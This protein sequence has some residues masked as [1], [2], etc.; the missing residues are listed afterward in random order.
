MKYKSKSIPICINNNAFYLN[1]HCQDKLISL[2]SID[3][4]YCD[5]DCSNDDFPYY[6]LYVTDFCNKN[7]KFC[8]NSIDNKNKLKHENITYD[9]DSLINFI[10]K[11]SSEFSLRFF[12]GEPT[13][14]FN[15][16]KEI[17]GKIE[18]EDIIGHFN[19]FTNGILLTNENLRYM[20]DKNI[21]LFLSIPNNLKELNSIQ[22]KNIF[23][24]IREE[25]M[26]DNVTARI[27]WNP[28]IESDLKTMVKTIIDSEI[29]LVSFTL[30]WG[31]II[32]LKEKK[33]I[34]TGLID[35]AD[36][37]IRE[38]KEYNFKYIGVHPIN[39]YIFK[40]V[41]GEYSDNICGAGKNLVSISTDGDLHPCHC[42]NYNND[43]KCGNIVDGNWTRAFDKQN[44]L[45]ISSCVN[46]EYNLFCKAKCFADSYFVNKDILAINKSKCE[47]EKI[48]IEISSY[49]LSELLKNP[50]QFKIYKRLLERG[51]KNYGNNI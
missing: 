34:K 28:K 44:T 1:P 13:L 39:S 29:K 5:V 18:K 4:G 20:K 30:E 46:C 12:G 41:K 49:I 47:C 9:L 15:D 43:F 10:K 14:K 42:F 25:Y 45:E 6:V 31:K 7:C 11:N 24:I 21:R 8:F 32:T 27:V 23:N 38:I 19:I 17:I 51:Y 37:Y 48:I 22:F 40:W 33:I 26:S 50:K 35:L 2:N 3:D 16:I 36:W